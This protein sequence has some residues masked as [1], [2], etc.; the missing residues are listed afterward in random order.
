[1]RFAQLPVTKKLEFKYMTDDEA[2]TNGE[3]LVKIVQKIRTCLYAA[4][5]VKF[6][7]SGVDV[8]ST[9]P[10]QIS[11]IGATCHPRRAKNF[12]IAA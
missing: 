11:P 8:R 6:S 12:K 2:A 7:F 4:I 9:P 5:L 10:G 3:N 1:M